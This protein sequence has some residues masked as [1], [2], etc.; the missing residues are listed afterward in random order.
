MLG[1]KSKAEKGKFRNSSKFRLYSKSR[2][3]GPFLPTVKLGNLSVRKTEA[4]IKCVEI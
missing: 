2:F 3:W 1:I 4:L